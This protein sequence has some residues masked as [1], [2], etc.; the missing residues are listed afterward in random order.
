MARHGGS[1]TT[2]PAEIAEAEQSW[3]QEDE[4]TVLTVRS[5]TACA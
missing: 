3:G 1:K 2:P 5:V 4:F